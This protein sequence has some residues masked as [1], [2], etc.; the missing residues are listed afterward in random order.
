[1]CF[2]VCDKIKVKVETT[3]EFPLDIKCT[4][5]ITEADMKAYQ[6]TKESQIQRRKEQDEGSEQEGGPRLRGVLQEINDQD[7]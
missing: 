7:F 3:T 2:T 5:L 1:L 4:M 6:K